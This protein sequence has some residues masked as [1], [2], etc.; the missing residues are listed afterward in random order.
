MKGVSPLL[1]TGALYSLGAN[2]LNNG[3][4]LRPPLGW[5]RNYHLTSHAYTAD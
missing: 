1:L 5:V 2:A 3:L 4:A